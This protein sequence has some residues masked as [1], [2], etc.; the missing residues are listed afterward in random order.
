MNSSQY[1]FLAIDPGIMR[2]NAEAPRSQNTLVETKAKAAFK[3]L[4][5]LT[6]WKRNSQILL[7]CRENAF[8]RISQLRAGY[9]RR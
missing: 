1:C 4:I 6:F 7:P 5:T 9:R 2:E 3:K 8:Q